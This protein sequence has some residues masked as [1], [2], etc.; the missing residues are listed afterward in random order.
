M[1]NRWTSWRNPQ[2]VNVVTASPASSNLANAILSLRF[3]CEKLEKG[4]SSLR[5]LGSTCGRERKK[6]TRMKPHTARI[7]ATLPPYHLFC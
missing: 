4:A 7:S 5:A 2:A 1:W 3:L 6:Q